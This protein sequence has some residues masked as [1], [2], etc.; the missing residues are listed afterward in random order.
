MFMS[1]TD[2]NV[3]Y[4]I[5]KVR[6]ENIKVACTT[7]SECGSAANPVLG[8][9]QLANFEKEVPP[10]KLVLLQHKVACTYCVCLPAG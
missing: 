9:P 5:A 3:M 4:T 6:V 2:L 1:M 10:R 8:V 7:A